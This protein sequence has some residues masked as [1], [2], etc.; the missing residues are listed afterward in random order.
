[1]F[2][3]GFLASSTTL[4]P[5]EPG[6]R[7][8][9]TVGCT[10]SSLDLHTPVALELDIRQPAHGIENFINPIYKEFLELERGIQSGFD[11]KKR[12]LL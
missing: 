6:S 10:I 8:I 7:G 1:M 9:G 4:A 5:A 11:R 2:E 3:T 12:L